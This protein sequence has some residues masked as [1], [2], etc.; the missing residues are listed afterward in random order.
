MVHLNCLFNGEDFHE[1]V[2]IE[3]GNEQN[4]ARLRVLVKDLLPSGLRDVDFRHLVVYKIPPV[5]AGDNTTL[6]EL[7]RRIAE[8]DVSL[9]KADILAT[10]RETFPSLPKGHIHVIFGIP[11]KI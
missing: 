5:V 8:E 2:S 3:I 10:M 6:Q 11:S 9:P 4:V 7:H 1:A